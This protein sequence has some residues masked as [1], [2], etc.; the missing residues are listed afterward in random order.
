MRVFGFNLKKGVAILIIILVLML[1][2]SL[3]YKFF[4]KE[5]LNKPDKTSSSSSQAR[6]SSPSK[7]A[8]DAC[9][10]IKDNYKLPDFTNM[11]EKLAKEP[12]VNDIPAKGSIRLR[13][14]H[15]IENCRIWD[16]TYYMSGGKIEEK[17]LNADIDVW[18][19]SDYVEKFNEKTLCEIINDAK[20]NG[21]L[22]RDSDL[23]KT[24]LLWRYK[25]MLGYRE[26]IGI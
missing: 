26:C 13:F 3:Y 1:I 2:I 9:A 20:N 4:S 19:H 21:D 24:T 10:N 11:K 8:V 6:V 12:F 17:N 22:G 14:Y 25:S 5:I 16:K 18:I 15:F 23:S 7:P